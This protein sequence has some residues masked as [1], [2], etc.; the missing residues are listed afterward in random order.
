MTTS[1]FLGNATINITPTGGSPIDVSDQ[2]T[3]CEVMV[4]FTYLDST[5]MGD[6]GTKAAQGLQM[7]SVNLDLFLSYGVGEVETLMAAIQTAGSC[8]ILVSPSGAT[9]S[10]SNPEFLITGCTTESNIAIMSTVGELSTVS[11][12]FTNGTWVRDII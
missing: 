1:T 6:T 11:L 9:E 12:S 2:C 7:V 3:K 5:S 10:A 8:N 4:G